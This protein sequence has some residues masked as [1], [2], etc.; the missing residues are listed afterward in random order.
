M[1]E[2]VLQTRCEPQERQARPPR[3]V[4][5]GFFWRKWGNLTEKHRWYFI[6]T[7]WCEGGIVSDTCGRR[8]TLMTIKELWMRDSPIKQSTQRMHESS[9]VELSNQSKTVSSKV[10]RSCP[11]TWK[12]QKLLFMS[13]GKAEWHKV[14][15]WKCWPCPLLP[16]LAST[17]KQTPPGERRNFKFR[18]WPSM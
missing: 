7:G 14:G 6:G 13:M 17:L 11:S 4:N 3:A 15:K 8:E 18:V 1:H 5:K 2:H 9:T 10:D 16:L 12:S